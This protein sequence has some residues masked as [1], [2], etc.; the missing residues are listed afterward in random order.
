[1]KKVWAMV[2][3]AV[4]GLALLGTSVYAIGGMGYGPGPGGCGYGAAA[5]KTVDVNALRAFQKETLPLRDEMMAKRLEIRNEF[6]KEKP[7]QNRIGALQK[8][9][10]DLRTKI[11]VAAEKQGLPAAGFGAGM[12]GRGMAMGPGMARG[13]YSGRGM[14]G[15]GMG[16]NGPC[17]SNCPMR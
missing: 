16:G 12:G 4:F 17:N 5:G 2:F 14:G 1:M 8:E 11:S 7:D 6:A 3:V 9:M 13:G 15:Q 10:I